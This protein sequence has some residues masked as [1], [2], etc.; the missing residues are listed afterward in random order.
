MNE[1]TKGILT[2]RYVNGTEQ[3]FEFTRAR[4]DQA[5]L[6]G[7]RIQELLSAKQI[8]LELEDRAL[9]IPVHT[10]QSIEVSPLPVKLPPNAI[11]NV[12]VIS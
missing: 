11:R 8:I 7:S 10:I 6:V 9:I 1:V 2:I 5:G 12:R 4:E 3:K